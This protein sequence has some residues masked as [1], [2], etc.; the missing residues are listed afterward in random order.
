MYVSFVF[1]QLINISQISYF[2]KSSKNDTCVDDQIVLVHYIAISCL[3]LTQNGVEVEHLG[4]LGGLGW[5]KLVKWGWTEHEDSH[6]PVNQVGIWIRG[7]YH[8]RK[9]GLLFSPNMA[10]SNR[11]FKPDYESGTNRA[12]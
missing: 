7:G 12:E 11:P 6:V 8:V 4:N 2:W 1:I 5:V 10:L 3:T 9:F